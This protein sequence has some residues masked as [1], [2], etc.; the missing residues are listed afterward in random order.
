VPRPRAPRWE[1]A[2]YFHVLKNGCK[3]ETLPLG[4]VD[5]VEP[6]LALFMVVA[7]RIAYLMRLARNCPGLD[8]ALF[9]SADEIRSTYLLSKK[10][11]PT[12]PPRLNQVTVWRPP[13]VRDQNVLK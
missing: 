1:I 7:W 10:P 12:Q 6:A 4:A 11:K 5:R 13:T 9:F 3:V 2:I 8:A